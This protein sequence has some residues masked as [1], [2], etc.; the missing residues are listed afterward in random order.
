MSGRKE[1]VA[2]YPGTFDAP[3]N[4]H[5][6]LIVRAAAIFDRLIVAVA[7]NASKRPLLTVEERVS[8]LGAITRGMP[9]VS[10]T[11]F[12]GLTVDFAREVGAKAI[13]RGLRA[14]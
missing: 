10:T 1:R 4:G 14:V 11:A 9:N 7:T 3:T 2:V 5:L 12:D 6:N 8:L 13:V